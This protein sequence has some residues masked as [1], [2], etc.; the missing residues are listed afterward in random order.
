MKTDVF[1]SHLEKDEQGKVIFS[2][3]LHEHL[4]EVSLNAQTFA[5]NALPGDSSLHHLA[6]LAGLAHD[7]GKCTT[8]FQNYLVH[9]HDT[10]SLKNHSLLSAFWGAFLVFREKYDAFLEA[11]LLFNVILNH[12]GNLENISDLL[13]NLGDLANPFLKDMIATEY[14]RKFT[15]LFEKHLPDLEKQSEVIDQDLK[16]INNNLP[17]VQSF[18]QEM[19]I[20]Q[21]AFYQFL[22]E[23]NNHYQKILKDQ[24]CQE[25]NFKRLILFSALIDAD[26]RDAVQI[27]KG[28]RRHLIP[29]H[30]VRFYVEENLKSKQSPLSPIREHLFRELQ[31]QA[32]SVN[33][34]QHIFTLTAPTGSGKTLS[35]LNFALLM[36]KRLQKERK[37]NPRI[38]YV[39][40]FTSIIDQN[41]EVFKRVIQNWDS[42]L[43]HD[44]SLLLK[45]HHLS[46]IAYHAGDEAYPLD[47]SLLLTES[48]ES[49]IIVTTFVQFFESIISNKNKMLKKYH[50]I[51]GS[52]IILD[53]V[54]NIPIE[55]WPLVREVMALLSEK[56]HS[57]F[58]LMT[59]TQ[60]LIFPEQKT[61]ELVKSKNFLFEQ[62]NRVRINHNPHPRQLSEFAQEFLDA[63]DERKSYAV[64]LN[65]IQSS[66]QFFQF[67][68][69][70]LSTNHRLFYLSTNIV[71][72]HRQQ[73]IAE[74]NVHLKKGIPLILVSTQV[75]EAGIDFDFDVIY[76]DFAPV[77]SLVQAAGRAN[78]NGSKAK[79]GEVHLVHLINEKKRSYAHFVYGKA[80][81]FVAN[82]IFEQVTQLP[83][84]AFMELVQEN[85]KQ[86][87]N[88]CDMSVGE[89]I[90]QKWWHECDESILPEFRLIDEKLNYVNVFV[91]VNE[92][93]QEI[94][95]RFL[96]L[97]YWEKDMRQRRLNFLKMRG[98][99]NQ[100]VFSIPAKLAKKHFWDYCHKPFQN[101]GLIELEMVEDYYH[102]QTGFIRYV[103]EETLFL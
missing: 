48:W 39:L 78:R 69:Q 72:L 75:I 67:L 57:Y 13:K 35:A 99:F 31:E 101:I 47:Q 82:K 4:N 89:K 10:G 79:N 49:E 40:P 60:P 5:T 24:H 41:F 93:A 45:H 29:D 38:I 6:F 58:I 77:D 44:S 84:R 42:Q 56:A 37:Y 66:I 18:L 7:F 83:E 103:D 12:H 33:L 19:R 64:I 27:Q 11:L 71:P 92:K 70:N 21:G 97:V 8:F 43:A 17:P 95:Q 30:I 15:I 98:E 94:W 22:I 81:L 25:F 73:R 68:E 3:P 87:V 91:S 46:E 20:G 36:K 65:T 90:F 96:T 80:H 59:A 23:A 50:N 1:Y 53:E 88:I 28:I 54:Q 55:Y 52:L 100:F 61:I 34:D 86:L 32:H 9:D 26:K 63:L 76:R 2:K 16:N 14:Q 62:L 102:H 51:F 85:Y 74:I